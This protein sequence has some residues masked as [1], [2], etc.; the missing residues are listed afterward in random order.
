MDT[1]LRDGEQ[2]PG[3]RL[4]A[5]EKIIIA[6]QLNK[7]NVDCIEAGFSASSLGDFNSVMQ[8]AKEFSKG[9]PVITAL[10]RAVKGDIDAV[11]NSVKYAHR[12]LI[13]I[14][15]G[16]SGIH[17]KKKFNKSIDEVINMGVESV[18][19]AKSLI[20][21]VQYSTEDASR[22]DFDTLWKTIEAVIKAGATIV[23]IPDTVGYAVPEEFGEIIKKINYRMKNINPDVLLSVHCH[24]DLGMATVNTLTAVKNGADRIE[25]TINGIGERAGNASL[26]E[27]VM[28]IKARSEF[29]QAQ[30]GIVTKELRNISTL[31]SRLMGLSVQVNKAIVGDNAFAHSSGIHQ[32]GLLKS[33][34]VY[35]IIRPEEVG[36]NDMEIVLTARSGKHALTDVVSTFGFDIKNEEINSKLYKEFLKFADEKKEIYY[37]ELYEFLKN[38]VDSLPEKMEIVNYK[39]Y[40]IKKV[41]SFIDRE[42]PSTA[43]EIVKDGV[44]YIDSAIGKDVIDSVANSIGR[45]VG[46]DYKLVDYN[47]FSMRGKTKVSMKIKYKDK[48]IH[49]RASEENFVLSVANCFINGVNKCIIE[50]KSNY[51]IE[52]KIV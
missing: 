10:A 44:N 28:A 24:N 29:Y 46:N 35:E 45:I 27:V 48:Y 21:N 30:T 17:V 22:T 20:N 2:V 6:R 25:C 47:I 36:L 23:N 7:L 8:I 42:Y 14:V 11:Y 40:T 5:E 18:K 12:P 26:E 52:Q 3:A 34:D 1:T 49:S 16:S 13:H 37:N 31:V 9:G 19:Y 43:I 38:F 39:L 32:D 4:N 33:R 15:L 50:E 41:Q 51:G